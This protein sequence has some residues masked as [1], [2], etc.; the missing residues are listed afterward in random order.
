MEKYLLP[1][2][3]YLSLL[4]RVETEESHNRFVDSMYITVY[5]NISATVNPRRR[6]PYRLRVPSE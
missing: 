6:I 5:L 4:R 1:R 3:Q 2:F